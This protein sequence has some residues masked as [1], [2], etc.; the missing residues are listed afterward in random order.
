MEVYSITY[1]YLTDDSRGRRT[2]KQFIQ[3]RGADLSL[4]L[5][6]RKVVAPRKEWKG[7]RRT[8]H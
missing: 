5:F 7:G 4:P 3:S 2:R 1:K 6:T 8:W